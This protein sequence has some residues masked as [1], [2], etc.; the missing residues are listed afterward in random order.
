MKDK[1]IITVFSVVIF[2]GIIKIYVFMTM[3]LPFGGVLDVLHGFVVLFIFIP[4]SVYLSTKLI[5]LIRK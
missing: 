3:P 1:I 2:I 4:A 5:D